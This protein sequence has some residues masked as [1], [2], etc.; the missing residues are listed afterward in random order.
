MDE[1]DKDV[2]SSL[3]LGAARGR[4]RKLLEVSLID[5]EAGDFQRLGKRNV[6]IAAC[7]VCRRAQSFNEVL[8]L[9]QV[10]HL[11]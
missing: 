4:C 5:L 7:L 8:Q 6:A 2:A 1:R 11:P 10:G 9:S 3:L